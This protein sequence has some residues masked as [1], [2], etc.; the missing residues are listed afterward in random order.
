MRAD[1][2]CFHCGLPLP[3]GDGWT[4]R[5]DGQARAVCCPGCKAVA[6]AIDTGGLSSYYDSRTAFAAQATTAVRSELQVYD[7]PE[8]QAGFVRSTG[9][10]ACETT[11]IMEGIRCAACVWLNE[12]HLASLPGITGAEINPASRCRQ[13]WPASNRSDTSR[14]RPRRQTRSRRASVKRVPRCGASLWPD[15]A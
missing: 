9:R 8:V 13:Y 11:L 4:A 2:A 14:G 10:D 7:Q 12:T 3:A 6:E 5:I 15:S 1:A